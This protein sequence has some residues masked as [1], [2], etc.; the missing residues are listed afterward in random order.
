MGVELSTLQMLTSSPICSLVGEEYLQRPLPAPQLQGLKDLK[1]WAQI[2]ESQTQG[3]CPASLTT[4]NTSASPTMPRRGPFALA[5]MGIGKLEWGL[6]NLFE[7]REA[8]A[9][10][11]LNLRRGPEVL[12]DCQRRLCLRT[13]QNPCRRQAQGHKSAHSI[14]S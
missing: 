9:S 14:C 12:Q 1:G 7:N 2:K 13:P 11:T 8:E 5:R 4:S 6:A 10:R 3:M